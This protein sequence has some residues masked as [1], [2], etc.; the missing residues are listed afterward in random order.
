M[1]KQIEDLPEGVVGYRMIG[2][3]TKADY[4]EALIPWVQGLIDSGEE[5][6]AVFEFGADFDG[7]EAGAAWEDALM[8][9]KME[10]SDHANWKRFAIVTDTGWIRHL[11]SL[12]HWMMP[13]EVKVY[14]LDQS[15]EA[16][17]WVAG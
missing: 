2:T 4:E 17:D 9:L 14:G 1:I 12:F 3:I 11:A 8:G 6:R 10:T 15:G 5:V 13:G 7:Y 16:S